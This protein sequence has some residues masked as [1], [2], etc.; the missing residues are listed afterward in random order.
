MNLETTRVSSARRYVAEKENK[1]AFTGDPDYN[2]SGLLNHEG[3]QVSS[4]AEGATGATSTAKKLW[5]NKTPQEILEDLRT[6]RKLARKKKLFQA[7][8]LL[9]ASNA[10]NELLKPYSDFSDKTVLDWLRG[11]KD[12]NFEMILE[13]EE[14]DSD[15]NGL[16][17]AVDC[18]CICDNRSEVLE[19]AIVEDLKLGDPVYDI[20]GTSEMAVTERTAGIILRHPASVF[21]GKGI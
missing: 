10:Y 8:V 5:A 15:Q 19:L 7:N 6:G 1:L 16:T 14:L 9:V 3:I 17:G 20:L 18:F 2:I 21:I 12:F 11:Q 13:A 4:V